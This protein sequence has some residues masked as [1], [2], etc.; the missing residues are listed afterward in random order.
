[1]YTHLI[2]FISA[3]TLIPEI[4]KHTYFSSGPTRPMTKLGHYISLRKG[5]WMLCNPSGNLWG[6]LCKGEGRKT[7]WQ[8][9]SLNDASLNSYDVLTPKFVL[10]LLLTKKRHQ[11][12]HRNRN[13]KLHSFSAGPLCNHD[14]TTLISL[15][16]FPCLY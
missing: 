15:L 12:G 6:Y 2:I 7:A 4:S 11:S 5:P 3:E 8:G 10:L 9:T 13:L 1:M 16:P 14:Q